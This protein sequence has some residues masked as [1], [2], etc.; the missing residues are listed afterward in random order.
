[1]VHHR[2]RTTGD[3]PTWQ[4]IGNERQPGPVGEVPEGCPHLTTEDSA[5]VSQAPPVGRSGSVG[6][7]WLRFI[8]NQ[9]HG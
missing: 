9:E 4:L 2:H 5:M 7:G 3:Q 1:M 8:A 6:F